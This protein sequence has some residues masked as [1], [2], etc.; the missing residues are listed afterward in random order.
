MRKH[1]GSM[2]NMGRENPSKMGLKEIVKEIVD[3]KA[4]KRSLGRK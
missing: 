2:D 4:D 1:A 3:L